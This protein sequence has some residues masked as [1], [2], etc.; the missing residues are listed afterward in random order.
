VPE[1]QGAQSFFR[2]KFDHNAQGFTVMSI[3]AHASIG[4][5]K[6]YSAQVCQDMWTE[7]GGLSVKL[8]GELKETAS[9]LHEQD[10]AGAYTY[11]YVHVYTYTYI[12]VYIYSYLYK[13]Q[14]CI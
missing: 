10:T 3:L 6:F 7:D 1:S 12:C 4:P 2:L 13:I 9:I 5:G 14:I 8:C 11:T